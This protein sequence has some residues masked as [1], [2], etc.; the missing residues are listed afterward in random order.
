MLCWIIL[1]LHRQMCNRC[2]PLSSAAHK[3]LHTVRL[4][5]WTAMPSLKVKK[6]AFL[7]VMMIKFKFKSFIKHKFQIFAVCCFLN[8]KTCCFFLLY[9]MSNEISLGF[10]WTKQVIWG[11]HHELEAFI[12]ETNNPLI[13]NVV[14]RLMA[15]SCLLQPLLTFDFYV[16]S[17]DLC[18]EVIA[19]RLTTIHRFLSESYYILSVQYEATAG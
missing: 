17:V 18:S 19:Q 14:D 8:V 3:I 2:Y 9:I 5:V 6:V 11:C 12:D 13:E 7:V 16:P 1:L 4:D 15:N 10:G